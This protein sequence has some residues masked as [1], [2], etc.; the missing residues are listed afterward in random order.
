MVWSPGVCNIARAGIAKNSLDLAPEVDSVPSNEL[1]AKSRS[2]RTS[3]PKRESFREPE[4]C[5]GLL[6]KIDNQCSPLI[7][8]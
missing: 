4:I 3:E 1:M 7:A 6:K 2:E 8:W 5:P